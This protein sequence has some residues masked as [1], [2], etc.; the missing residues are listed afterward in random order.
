MKKKRVSFVLTIAAFS[1][2]MILN[3]CSVD[4]ATPSTSTGGYTGGGGSGGGGG[5]PVASSISV[6]PDSSSIIVGAST[7]LRAAVRDQNGNTMSGISVTFSIVTGAGTLT[8]STGIA[9]TDA[10][11]QAVVQFTSTTTPGPVGVQATVAS[12]TPA[13]T[14]TVA[15]IAVT[16]TA[17]A[18]PSS[19][20]MSSLPT[21]IDVGGQ[22]SI[23]VIVRDNV[24]NLLSNKGVDFTFTVGGTLGVLSAATATTNVSGQATITF[25]AGTTPG[26]V[27][28]RATATGFPVATSTASV[29]I[30]SLPASISATVANSSISVLSSTNITAQ[31]LNS[32]GQQVSDGTVVTFTTINT[33]GGT[34]TESATTVGG[35]ASGTYLAG[36][37]PGQVTVTVSCA[38]GA[39]TPATVIITVVEPTI[40][41]IE[42]ISATPNIIGVKSAGT[43]VT[44]TVIFAV[45]TT[46][47]GDAPDGRRVLFTMTGPN[48]G[49]YIGDPDATPS[50]HEASTSQGKVSIIVN[51]GNVS[52]PI[53]IIATVL[54]NSGLPTAVTTATAA[55][56]IGGGF[57]SARHL[58][59]A[60]SRFNLPGLAWYGREATLTV[61][62]ADRFGNYNVMPATTVSFYIEAGAVDA[63]NITDAVGQTTAIVRTQ[64]PE[65]QDVAPLPWE[66]AALLTYTATPPGAALPVTYNPRDGWVRVIAVTRG[67]EKFM[68]ANAN[69]LYDLGEAFDDLGEPFIDANGNGVRDGVTEP[70]TDG[71]GNGKYDRGELFT[72]SDLNGVHDEAEFYVDTNQNGSYDGPNGTWDTD[73]NI[74]TGMDLVFSG[75]PIIDFS[76]PRYDVCASTYEPYYDSNG[77]GIVDPLTEPFSDVNHNGIW[78]NVSTAPP[79]QDLEI[80]VHDINMN[81]ITGG[82]E[83]VVTTS[84]GNLSSGTI[85]ADFADALSFGPYR[86]AV[87][88]CDNELGF[89]DSD[90]DTGPQSGGIKVDVNWNT[91][92]TSLLNVQRTLSGTAY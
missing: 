14:S 29:R 69:G 36:N 4:T 44:S 62:V 13:L 41:S 7:N 55:V 87:T 28:I 42:F 3:A 16:A 71:N 27:T 33:L 58:S 23:S 34:L 72:D 57:P 40:G 59:M 26:T 31:V 17:V 74:W 35:Y 51:S 54:D 73:I 60:T 79:C 65:P 78:D 50:S 11:G 21:D 66:A 6:V 2:L 81:N 88:I 39:A 53:R 15:T 61:Y 92:G 24:G 52:G 20:S 80:T 5:A 89:G 32:A 75:S 8:P 38:T 47:G 82:S 10:A 84:A 85:T 22:S 91:M 43:N 12:V 90:L 45:K 77:D 30:N 67:E 18:D 70:F 25:T 9:T 64:G 86:Q 83:L 76:I 49:E 37:T 19:L 1:I 63:S 48:G 56:S 46:T 68:D